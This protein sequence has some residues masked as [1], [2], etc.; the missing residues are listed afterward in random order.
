MIGV[1]DV[2][3][4]ALTWG[5]QRRLMCPACKRYIHVADETTCPTCGRAYHRVDDENYEVTRVKE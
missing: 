3:K 5:T 1:G 2:V 4:L